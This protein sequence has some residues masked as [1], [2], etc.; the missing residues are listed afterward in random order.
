[1]T[2]VHGRKRYAVGTRFCSR[3]LRN[4]RDGIVEPRLLS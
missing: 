4:L 1:M 3:W 2:L